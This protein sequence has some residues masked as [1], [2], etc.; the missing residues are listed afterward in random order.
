M[1]L[2]EKLCT[3]LM[4]GGKPDIRL[5]MQ[6]RPI[7]QI[8]R[9]EENGVKNMLKV[10]TALLFDFCN[11]LN[12]VRPMNDQ[13]II[14]AAAALL[15]ECYNYRIEDYVCMFTMAKRGRLVKIMDR[16]DITII[17]EISKAYWAH[18]EVEIERIEDEEHRKRKR[19][20]SFIPAPETPEEIEAS[21][22]F[23]KILE[24]LKQ[25]PDP[26]RNP[27]GTRIK[28]E[29]EEKGLEEQERRAMY[30]QMLK[31]RQEK[32]Q[33]SKYYA[34][35][36]PLRWVQ[37]RLVKSKLVGVLCT[38]K[39]VHIKGDGMEVTGTDQY[40]YQVTDFLALN[41]ISIQIILNDNKNQL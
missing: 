22:R 23:A 24:I 31:R 6:H 4:P 41:D 28:E 18:R 17:L 21:K 1:Q 37:H 19:E 16:M 5:I 2:T 11:S 26:V 9:S 34:K 40:G 29:M 32:A 3:E 13:Q 39:I 33:Q 15:D 12:V 8:V 14:E 25:A 27:I 10:L 36:M 35:D 30:Q 38:G 7:I 20:E